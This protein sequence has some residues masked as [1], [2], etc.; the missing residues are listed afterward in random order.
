MFNNDLKW[1][2]TSLVLITVTV[3]GGLFS[4]VSIKNVKLENTKLDTEITKLE[5][6]NSKLSEN[7]NS[8]NAKLQTTNTE[9][10]VEEANKK[11][12]DV[13]NKFIELYP[14]YDIK[15]VEDKKKELEKI[16]TQSIADSIVPE[17]MIASSKKTLDSTDT[18]QGEAYSSD[19]T[20]KSR[21]A[22]STVYMNVVNDDQ[23]KYFAEVNYKTES[24]SGDTEN[25]VYINFIVTNKDGKILV[26]DYDIKYL[27]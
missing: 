9:G 6:K 19:P 14:S 7:I 25:T 18:K 12:N 16:A 2:F 24:S 13:A 17:D 11:I 21:Y 22:N 20:F 27:N 8:L 10:S 1:K 26:T 5:E 4:A 23:I 15:T 3:F